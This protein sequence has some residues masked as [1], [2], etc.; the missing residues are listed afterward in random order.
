MNT[1]FETLKSLEGDLEDV[2][3]R[4]RLRLQRTTLQGAIRRNT[5]RTWMKVAG[6]AAAFL[7]VA[8]S[9]G[10]IASGG[11]VFPVMSGADGAGDAPAAARRAVG[12]EDAGGAPEPAPPNASPIPADYSEGASDLDQNLGNQ[13]LGVRPSA[14]G[15]QQQQ[16][17]SKIVRDGRIGIVVDD[18]AFGESVGELTFIAERHGGFVLSSST[19]NE[20]SGTFVLRIPERQFDQARN[21]I[22]DLATRVR[23]EEVRGDDVTAEFIDF[24]A[25]LRILQTRRELLFD[26]FQQADTTDEILR[27]SSQLDEVTLRIEEIQGQLRFLKDQVAESTL[28][29]SIQERNAPAVTGEQDVDNPDLGSSIDLGVQGFLRIVGA[30]IVGLGYLIPITALAVAAWMAVWFVRRRRAIS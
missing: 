25:R 9:I 13:R 7:V 24:H 27:M 17:L 23:F 12:S 30:V 8:G 2:A 21:D 18:G 1:E 15:G 16:D 6:I 3:S 29:V 5:G 22:R 4:E 28:R 26:L 10:F 14:D 11:G 20:R 19:S